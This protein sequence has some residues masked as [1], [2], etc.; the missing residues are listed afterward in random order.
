M[1]VS[2]SDEADAGQVCGGVSWSSFRTGRGSEAA[3]GGGYEN[4]P[5]GINEKTSSFLKTA[6]LVTLF[7]PQAA[8]FADGCA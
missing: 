3:H 4:P 7:Q 6:R 1:S 2:S 8:V 5:P